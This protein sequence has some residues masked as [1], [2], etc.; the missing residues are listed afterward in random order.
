M[1]YTPTTWVNNVPPTLFHVFLNNAETQYQKVLDD[2]PV[3]DIT[4]NPSLRTLGTGAQ[5]ASAGNH[6]H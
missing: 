3:D 6:S 2:A 5:Q 4:A 1:A